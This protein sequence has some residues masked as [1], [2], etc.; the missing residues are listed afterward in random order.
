MKG[1]RWLNVLDLLLMVAIFAVAFWTVSRLPATV[2]VHFGFSGLPDHFEPR[3]QASW[4]LFLLPIFFGFGYLL[5]RGLSSLNAKA[6]QN[7]AVLEQVS[8]VLLVFAL[9]LELGIGFA[10]LSGTAFDMLRL[11]L[12]GLGV[13]FALMGSALPR[14]RPNVF[15]G[16]RLFYTLSS[17]LAWQKI[18]RIGGWWMTVYGLVLLGIS[19]IPLE[20]VAAFTVLTVPV[21]VFAG[22]FVLNARA[23]TFW[24]QDPLRRS[25]R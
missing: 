6:K 24:T 1:F 3:A 4:I 8:S 12:A 21:V 20:R 5:L 25:V 7:K 10:M 16:I 14:T 13:L 18:H 11:V 17:D 2:P 15:V 19:L 9:A 23:K 22:L